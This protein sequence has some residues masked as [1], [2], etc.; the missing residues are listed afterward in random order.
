MNP[1]TRTLAFR[2]GAGPTSTLGFERVRRLTLVRALVPAPRTAGAP[3]EHV[4]AA[5]QEREYRL[6]VPGGKET[7][8]GRTAGFVQAAEGLYLYTPLDEERALQRVFVPASG[9]T[10]CA[11]APSAE[12]VAA[13]RWIA[14]PAELLRALEHQR[15]MPILR[16]GEALLNLGLVTEQQLNRALSRQRG[17]VP[18]GKMLVDSGVISQTDLRTALAHKMGYPLV[19]L[20]RF[21]VDPAVARKLPLKLATECLAVPLF[22]HADKL[23]VAVDRPS[24]VPRLQAVRAFAQLQVLP[25]L[26]SKSQ[27]MLKLDELAHD[28]IWSQHVFSRL[29]FAPTTI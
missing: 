23:I 21:P 22:V 25:V 1:S 26:A 27:I 5:A 9:Y 19:D 16:I 14:A 4:P 15:Q 29:V 6:T 28:D 11:F 13:E 20:T 17:D 7:I 3:M 10:D 2:V 12:E 8:S 18:L 24:R